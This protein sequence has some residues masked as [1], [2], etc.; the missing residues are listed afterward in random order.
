MIWPT[1]ALARYKPHELKPGAQIERVVAIEP[2]LADR[3]GDVLLAQ[4]KTEEAKTQY[5]AA[6]KAL[7]AGNAKVGEREDLKWKYQ[8][9]MEGTAPGEKLVLI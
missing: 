6:W 9:H 3:R 7:D 2:L 8:Q 1:P 5:E 4:G